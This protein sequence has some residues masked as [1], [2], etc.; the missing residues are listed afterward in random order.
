MCDE[1]IRQELHNRYVSLPDTYSIPDNSVLVIGAQPGGKRNIGQKD[2]NGT[3]NERPFYNKPNYYTYDIA[4]SANKLRHIQGDFNNIPVNKD[5]SKLYCERFDLVIFDFSVYKFLT[6]IESLKDIMIMV[7]PG[8][9][10]IFE[11][12][13]IGTMIED[14]QSFI[15]NP[16]VYR[17]NY[18]KRIIRNIQKQISDDI[19]Q[20]Q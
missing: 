16:K 3:I 1:D 20:L 5:I 15:E 9:F 13:T 10:C 11:M 8:G 14:M 19:I 4:A 12:N 6:D 17:S 7:K 2:V 18:L